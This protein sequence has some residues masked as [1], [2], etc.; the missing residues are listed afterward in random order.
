MVRVLD[1][2]NSIHS[3][4][5]SAVRAILKAHGEGQARSELTVELRLSSPGADCTNTEQIGQELRRDGV[6]HLTGKRHTLL[7]QV[8][9]ELSRDAQTLVDLEGVIDVWDV[10][11]T[12][13]SDC[14]TGL[15]KVGAHD[16]EEILLVLLLHLDEAVAVLESGLGVVDRAGTDDDKK[17]AV[18]VAALDDFDGLIAALEN[19]FS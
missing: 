14:C 8:N 19:G 12:L 17:P 5:K 13:P 16:D 6:Q 18:L 4:I 10:N 15:L 2:A 9:K 11:Q 3:N 1:G 7:G